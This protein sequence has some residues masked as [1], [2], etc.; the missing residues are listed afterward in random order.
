MVKRKNSQELPKPVR[1]RS[2]TDDYDKQ[3]KYSKLYKSGRKYHNLLNTDSSKYKPTVSFDKRSDDTIA[4][5][6]TTARGNPRSR[7]EIELREDTQL[8]HTERPKK[9]FGNMTIHQFVNRFT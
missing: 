4:S 7:E 6:T 8:F 5:S 3:E 2:I 1:K 9:L